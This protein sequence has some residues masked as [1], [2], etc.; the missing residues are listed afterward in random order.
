MSKS[1]SPSISETE[2]EIA[3]SISVAI[4]C[5]TLNLP[6]PSTPLYHPIGLSPPAPKT[7]SKYPSPSMSAE[8]I[9]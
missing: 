3:I 8:I 1:P 2:I 7:V 9:A 5:C 6:C 4:L